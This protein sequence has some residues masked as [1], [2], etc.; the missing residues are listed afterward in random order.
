MNCGARVVHQPDGT[1]C[2]ATA[3]EDSAKVDGGVAAGQGWYVISVTDY[4]HAVLLRLQRCQGPAAV[5]CQALLI[6][7]WQS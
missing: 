7:F 5:L 2:S 6:K 1:V 4:D 3:A